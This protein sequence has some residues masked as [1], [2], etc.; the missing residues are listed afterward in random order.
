MREQRKA[1]NLWLFDL[2]AVASV[3]S[4]Y[5]VEIQDDFV[6]IVRMPSALPDPNWTPN[7]FWRPDGQ[8]FSIPS[9]TR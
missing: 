3:L 4:E 6:E 1:D 5:G 7:R 2:K 9:D 8:S